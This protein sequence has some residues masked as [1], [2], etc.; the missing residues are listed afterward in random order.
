MKTH[1]HTKKTDRNPLDWAEDTNTNVLS[2]YRVFLTSIAGNT[3]YSARATHPVTHVA[4]HDTASQ[5][6]YPVDLYINTFAFVSHRNHF[7]YY[8]A[9]SFLSPYLFTPITPPTTSFRRRAAYISVALSMLIT[10]VIRR[11]NWGGSVS[12]SSLPPSFVGARMSGL[13][14]MHAK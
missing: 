5:P 11:V 13:G 4:T 9:S 10:H 7:L 6:S 2:V 1:T 3:S 8:F 14:E 12:A